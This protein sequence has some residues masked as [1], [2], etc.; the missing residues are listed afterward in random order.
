M[1]ASPARQQIRQW[2]GIAMTETRSDAL[3]SR[4]ILSGRHLQPPG[5]APEALEVPG[6][7][8]SR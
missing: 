4:S 5:R 8:A 1:A 6:G 2:S 3:M 7:N